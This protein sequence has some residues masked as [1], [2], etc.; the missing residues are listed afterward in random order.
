[1]NENKVYEFKNCASRNS[2]A[3]WTFSFV[4]SLKKA[5]LPPNLF[6]STLLIIC[7]LNNSYLER[8]EIVI[9]YFKIYFLYLYFIENNKYTTE[10]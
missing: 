5:C 1:M 8:K 9:I 2:N 6:T 10:I 4:D 7:I 3:K